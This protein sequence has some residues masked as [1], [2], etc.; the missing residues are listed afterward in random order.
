MSIISATNLAQFAYVM[1]HSFASYFKTQIF[2]GLNRL[3]N[4]SKSLLLMPYIRVLSFSG[5]VYHESTF[6]DSAR[7]GDVLSDVKSESWQ[8]LG[9]KV[10]VKVGGVPG[11]FESEFL[12]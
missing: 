12:M 9:V 2:Y 5:E 10:G 1:H 11:L 4:Y 6:S 3:K 8:V 7:V